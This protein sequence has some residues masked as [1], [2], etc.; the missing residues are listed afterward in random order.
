MIPETGRPKEYVKGPDVGSK[1][2]RTQRR[3][4]KL[5]AGQSN[6]NGFITV[7]ATVHPSPLRV[8]SPAPA[9]SV[10]DTMSEPNGD[11]PTESP[12]ASSSTMLTMAGSSSLPETLSVETR[13]PESTRRCV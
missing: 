3:Y 7:R 5:L 1:S 10:L 11:E 8:E 6:L 4:R 13:E 9:N 2:A 12:E